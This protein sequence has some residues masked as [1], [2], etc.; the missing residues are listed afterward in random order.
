MCL[1][2]GGMQ[3]RLIFRAGSADCAP[4][5][6]LRTPLPER[7][8]RRGRRR[9]GAA[10]PRRPDVR[11]GHP[12]L[13]SL[14]AGL[15]SAIL[16]ALGHQRRLWGTNS[17]ERSNGQAPEEAASR[18]R[19]P[20]IRL[21]ARGAPLRA[22]ARPPGGAAGGRGRR[23]AGRQARRGQGWP[24]GR[25]IS[26]SSCTCRVPPRSGPCRPWR[27]CRCRGDSASACW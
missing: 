20:R 17:P 16:A 25:E 26:V 11:C 14:D 10:R 8:L 21:N 24:G 5:P 22:R 1:K 13:R 3:A 6:G 7:S 2:S 9:L 27:A 15:C 18:S 19:M 4:G 12:G 23:P